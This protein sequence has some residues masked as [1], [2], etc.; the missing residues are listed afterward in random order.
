MIKGIV[1]LVLF[2]TLALLMG[3]LVSKIHLPAILGWLLTGMII[4]PHALNWMDSSI[5]DAQWFH[6]LSNIGEVFVGMLIGTELIL[7]ELKKSGKQ[8][9]I[10]CL[11]EGITTFIFVSVAFF[12]F[13]DIPMSI[14]L[15]FGAIA[16]ATAPAPSLSIVKEYNAQGPVSKTLIPLAALDD[17]LALIVFFLVIGLVS[18]SMTGEGVNVFAILMM[19]VLPL[20]L[21]AITGL[22]GAKVLKKE[23]NKWQTILKVTALIILTVAI[24]VYINENILSINLVLSGISFAAFIANMVEEERLNEIMKDINPIIGIALV[25]VILDL[26]APL[27]YN[28]I[29]GAGLLTA[30][31]IISR[32]LG[33]IV[34]SYTGGKISKA[35]KNV[36]KYLGLSL[37]PHSGVSLIFT[38][39]AVSTLSPYVPEH[40]AMIQGTIAAA[41]VINEIIAVF[42]AKQAFK[43]SGE[44]KLEKKERLDEVIN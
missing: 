33:K 26:G 24:G 30:I 34:G 14:A 29:F 32:G 22:I 19:I 6:I 8:I 5:M 39:I 38:G 7:K 2:I 37:L 40:A 36:C 43:M 15:V 44:I 20:A 25:L 41:A 16:L 42:L 28:L 3:K 21:G 31:Y 4:G 10:I 17:I 18:G 27:D 1:L 11:F 12:I 23:C 9:L 13:A 35:E